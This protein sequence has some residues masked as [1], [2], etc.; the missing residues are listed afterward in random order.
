MIRIAVVDDHPLILDGVRGWCAAADPPITVVATFADPRQFLAGPPGAV[1]VVVCDLRFAGRAPDLVTLRRICE[2]NYRVVVLSEQ[3]DPDV[4][5]ECLDIGAVSYLS[6]EE[7]R[8]H[9]IASLQ[10]AVAARPY[11]S[12]TMRKAMH[13]G[14]SAAKPRLSNREREVLLFWFQ[15]ESKALVARELY[16]TVG[17]VDTHLERIRAKYAAVGRSAPT[18]A[19]L[20]ARAIKDGLITPD[21]V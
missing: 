20:V 12:S 10:A 8:E 6:K 11:S 18:K 19:A 7:G 5:L 17:T 4:V 9:L 3:T 14:R 1:D 21:E 13:L 16:I 15:T 2:Q